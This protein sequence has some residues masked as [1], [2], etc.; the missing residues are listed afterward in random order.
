MREGKNNMLLPCDI[1]ERIRVARDDV[2]ELFLK[3]PFESSKSQ[4]LEPFLNPQNH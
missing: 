2:E 4:D 1:G 3:N